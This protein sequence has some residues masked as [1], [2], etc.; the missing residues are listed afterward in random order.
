MKLSLSL[1]QLQS[2]SRVKE[3]KMKKN[4]N[5]HLLTMMKRKRY[6]PLSLKTI[7]GLSLTESLRIYPSYSCKA[8]ASLLDTS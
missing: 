4:N 2:K 1:K 5:N 3:T 8:R 6:L 7:N